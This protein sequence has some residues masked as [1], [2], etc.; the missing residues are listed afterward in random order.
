MLHK[1]KKVP[2]RGVSLVLVHTYASG[3]ICFYR[4]PR[5]IAWFNWEKVPPSICVSPCNLELCQILIYLSQLE[6]EF[7]V[8][9]AVHLG[10]KHG[11]KWLQRLRSLR[12][13][14]MRHQQR[15]R[16]RETRGVRAYH[17]LPFFVVTPL[18]TNPRAD[19]ADGGGNMKAISHPRG[20]VSHMIHKRKSDRKNIL[21]VRT[22]TFHVIVCLLQSVH[23]A[24]FNLTSAQRHLFIAS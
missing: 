13:Q 16:A 1:K 23:S 8:E 5:T 14:H 2:K 3:Y 9:V 17:V 10:S 4:R 18:T 21:L 20:E 15:R 7:L 22:C 11:K 19:G 6:R 24:F 12:N